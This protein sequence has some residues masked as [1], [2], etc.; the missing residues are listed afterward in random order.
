M[1]WI[2]YKNEF[3]WDGSWRD[4]YILNTTIEDWD[5]FINFLR[6][7]GYSAAALPD[8]LSNIFTD[9]AIRPLLTINV[10]GV[11]LNCHFFT[12]KEIELDLDPREV[13]G[14]DKAKELF[15]FMGAVGRA[16]QMTVR[17][18]PENLSERPIFEFSPETGTL[19][20]YPCEADK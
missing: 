14:E 18:T 7:N 17:M 13:T 6:N 20:Y 8:D 5:K 9:D 16:L 4:I 1:N 10:A 19:S 11:T 3:A 15:N 2:S 12:E